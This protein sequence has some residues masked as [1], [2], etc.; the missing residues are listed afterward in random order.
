MMEF[1]RFIVLIKLHYL[2]TC[3][4]WKKVVF[5]IVT[6]MSQANAHVHVR[7]IFYTLRDFP[8]WIEVYKKIMSSFLSLHA[9]LNIAH[10]LYQN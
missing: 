9:K 8:M 4:Y 7:A 1:H 2:I 10:I 3:K 6:K 5:A